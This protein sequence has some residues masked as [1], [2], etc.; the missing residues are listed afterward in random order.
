M[1]PRQSPD[2]LQIR[3]LGAEVIARMMTGEPIAALGVGFEHLP[4]PWATGARRIEPANGDGRRLAAEDWLAELQDGE[5]LR[6]LIYACDPASS[7]CPFPTWADLAKHLPAIQWE[8]PGW[9]PRGLLTLLVG[10]SGEGKSALA[11]ALAAC[12]TQG[13]QWPDGTP[14]RNPGAVVWAE[15]ES[16][17]AV[18]LDRAQAWKLPLDRIHMP[19]V[20]DILETIQ[21]DTAEGWASLEEVCRRPDVRLVIVDS[22]SGAHR[23]DENSAEIRDL[24]TRLASLAQAAG[25]AVVVVHHLRKRGLFDGGKVDLDRVRGSSV[26]VQWARVVLA[27]DRPN[28]EYEPDRVRLCQIKNNLARFPEPLGFEITDAGVHFGEAPQEPKAETQLDKATDLLKALLAREP[29][30]STRLQEEAEGAGVAWTT[31]KRAKEIL[32]VVAVR[33]GKT[34]RWSWALP[35]RP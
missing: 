3:P 29:V 28:A 11:L 10:A 32:G 12:V 7:F 14:V 35:A 22:L 25:L 26:I 24:L 8:W 31:L 17:Q 34:G 4:E 27:I 20:N 2:H 16:A 30:P 23:R 19:R 13:R 21:L 5:G 33:D 15:T 18:N 9:I 6:R 1:T